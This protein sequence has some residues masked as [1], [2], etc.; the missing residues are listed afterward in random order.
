MVPSTSST[1]ENATARNANT[2]M[3]GFRMRPAVTPKRSMRRPVPKSCRKTVVPF[4]A[5]SIIA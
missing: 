4:T 5:R 2:M 1:G 3:S